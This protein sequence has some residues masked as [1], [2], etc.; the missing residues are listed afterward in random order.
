MQKYRNCQAACDCSDSKLSETVDPR[1][2]P[3]TEPCEAVQ[4]SFSASGMES[5]K[6]GFHGALKAIVNHAIGIEQVRGLG[7]RVLYG[8]R[9]SLRNCR[10]VIFIVSVLAT[11]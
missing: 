1:S 9:R 10:V 11:Q 5:G 6:D 8:V 2:D 3:K 4:C 7:L